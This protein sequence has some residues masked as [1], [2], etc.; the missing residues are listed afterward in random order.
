MHMVRIGEIYCPVA[1]HLLTQH[2]RVDCKREKENRKS[3]VCALVCVHRLTCAAFQF[4]FL[5]SGQYNAHKRL[6][7]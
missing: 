2:L 4:Y 3:R 6:K 7:I 1:Y 5:C